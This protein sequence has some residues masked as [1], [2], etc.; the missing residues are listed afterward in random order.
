MASANHN[1]EGSSIIEWDSS[2]DTKDGAGAINALLADA[3]AQDFYKYIKTCYASCV[4]V[5]LLLNLQN[6]ILVERSFFAFAGD[7]ARVAISWDAYADSP[8]DDYYDDY[9]AL[10][11]DLMIL[12]FNGS[13][14]ESSISSVNNYEMVEFTVPQTGLY[15]MR[16][17]SFGPGTSEQ[18]TNSLGI[19]LVLTPTSHFETYLPIGLYD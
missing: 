19:A 13:V 6:P 8:G 11:L 9:L 2:E 15:T 16:V 12:D 5:R 17:K 10:D 18:I 1:I 14:I 7:N 3:T 4:R